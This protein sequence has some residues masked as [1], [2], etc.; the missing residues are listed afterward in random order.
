MNRACLQVLADCAA[1]EQCRDMAQQQGNDWKKPLHIQPVHFV[2]LM[3]L[4]I[5]DAYSEH[6]IQIDFGHSASHH[7]KDVTPDLQ[8][9]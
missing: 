2:N 3:Q 4:V 1:A 8:R 9:I 5:T 6:V 7:V